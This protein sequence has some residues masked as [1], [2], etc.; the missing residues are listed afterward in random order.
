MKIIFILIVIGFSLVNNGWSSESGLDL[1]SMHED[2]LE[3]LLKKTPESTLKVD[4]LYE[5]AYRHSWD[6]EEKWD[7]GEK[8]LELA[9]FAKNLAIQLNYQKGQVDSFCILG[10]IHFLNGDFVR[11]RKWFEKALELAKEIKYRTGEAMAN[12]GIGRYHQVRGE[13]PA[14]LENFLKSEELCKSSIDQSSKRALAAAYYGLGA[15]YYYD[16][17]DYREARR[18]FDKLLN[19]GEKIKDDVIITS[20][21]YTIGVMALGMGESEEAR[22]KFKICLGRS[23][24]LELMYNQANA[25]EGLG[26]IFFEKQCYYIA[27][28]YYNESL[29]LF[30][31]TR[32]RFQI[33]EINRR[34]GRLYNKLGEVESSKVNYEKAFKYLYEALKFA[35]SAKI[36]KTIEGACEEIIKSCLKLGRNEEASDYYKLLLETK[37][38][39]RKNEMIKFKL[40]RDSEKKTE[41][42]RI[43]RFGLIIGLTV[44]I[45][46]L[47]VVLRNY[48]KLRKQ[49]K[50]IEKQSIKL[51]EALIKEK[52]ISD[53][54]DN[55]M[56]TVSHQYKTPLAVID[57][58]AQILKNYLTKLSGREIEEHVDKILLN[59]KKMTGLIDP[60]LKFGKKFAPGYYDLNWICK[61]FT[62]KIKSDEGIEHIIEFKS[63]GDCVKVKLDKDFMNIILSNLLNNSI[64]YSPEGSKVIVEL[65]CDKDFALIKIIDQGI[66]IP[67]DYL[68]RRF[69]RFH[70]G[71]NVGS[72]LGTGLGLAIVKRYTDLHGGII[73]IET[74]L[75][76][77]TTVTV[78]IPKT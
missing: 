56:H 76:A 52:Q 22:K 50:Q 21:Y 37:K 29:E 17:A 60:L 12:N 41:K 40:I 31:G 16:P 11:S 23:K 54:K 27:L 1:I 30:L 74:K 39:L 69:E 49:K 48:M 36:P 6:G 65:L 24:N 75:N 51:E 14:A 25:N 38:S 78:K 64:K 44:L 63:S 5:L 9:K 72:V 3:A 18:Y 58:S 59:L 43:R 62:E 8:P 42:E 77:G 45:I 67:S 70:R 7:L 61:D 32:N 4:I 55:L 10:Q 19:I 35:Q 73:S 33:A 20:G 57:S 71:S 15:I 34:I 2:K 68:D 47:V 66:G 53:H 26:D 13:F 46:V 28:H